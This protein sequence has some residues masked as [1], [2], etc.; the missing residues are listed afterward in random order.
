M[1]QN[2]DAPVAVV[3]GASR[4]AGKGIARALGAA[5]MTVYVT[6][7]SQNEGDAPLP[8]TIHETAREIDALG[9][10]GIAVACDHADDAQV[11]ALFGRVERESGRLDIL[12]NNATYLHDQLILPGPFWEKSLDLVNILDVGLRSAY[13]ASWH[14]AAL[15]VKRRSGLIAFTSSFGA[16]CYMHGAA[17]GAQK[18]GVDKFAKDM[19]V[20]LKPF[21]VAAVSIWMGPLRTERTTRVWEEHPDLYKE[22][23]LVAESPE[24]T[25]RVIHAIHGDPQRMAWSGQVLVGAEAALRYGIADLDGKQPP[26]Y[27]ELL[28][29]PVQAHPA[30]VA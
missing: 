16:S 21:D 18:S 2:H 11:K 22:F 3:T 5:G 24:F 29:G 26:S 4:G 8:G 25:G 17:Y 1:T 14:A 7:R 19:A 23:S 12:V 10:R 30:I 27:R 15:M 28:G 13:V 6:G 20:D 9:G